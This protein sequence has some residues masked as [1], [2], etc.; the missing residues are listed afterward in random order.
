MTTVQVRGLNELLR[1]LDNVQ[2]LRAAVKALRASA[3]HIKG[4]VADYPTSTMANQPKTYPGRWYERGFGPKWARKDGSVG[5]AKSSETLGRKWTTAARNGGLTQ[6]VGNNVSYGPY[7]QDRDEQN[8]ALAGYGW[9]TIQD[10]T[11]E[12]SDRIL[13]F[14]KDEIDRALSGQ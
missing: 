11:E 8:K 7:V 2:G 12:E 14:V 4:K 13:R 6:V 1:K 10:V 3:V 9:K 5:G